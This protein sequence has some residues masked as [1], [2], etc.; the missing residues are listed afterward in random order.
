[1]RTANLIDGW[2]GGSALRSQSWENFVNYSLASVGLRPPHIMQNF[3]VNN[4]VASFYDALRAG[5]APVVGGSEGTAVVEACEM[6]IESGLAFA[7]QLG[8]EHVA[9]R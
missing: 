5:R 7:R 9:A 3:S 6:V 1:M 4:S 2:R 8:G